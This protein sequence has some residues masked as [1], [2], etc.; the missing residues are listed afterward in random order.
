MQGEH[1]MRT[2][3]KDGARLLM[4]GAAL[5]TVGAVMAYSGVSTDRY[6]LPGDRDDRQHATAPGAQMSDSAVTGDSEVITGLPGTSAL[7]RPR[8]AGAA[9]VALAVLGVGMMIRRRRRAAGPGEEI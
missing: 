9:G 5:A 8:M 2:W 4:T 6:T 7:T 1:F 3:I